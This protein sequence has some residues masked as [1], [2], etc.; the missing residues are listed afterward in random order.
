MFSVPEFATPLIPVVFF[1]TIKLHC[2]HVVFKPTFSPQLSLSD[3]H[4]PPSHPRH[5]AKNSKTIF[6]NFCVEIK[7]I[8][9]DTESMFQHT[10]LLEPTTMCRAGV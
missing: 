7:A 8:Y 5:V 9:L 2:G 3:R 10:L 4:C 1:D 6:T